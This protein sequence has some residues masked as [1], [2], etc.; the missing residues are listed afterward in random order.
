MDASSAHPPGEEKSK[1]LPPSSPFLLS[2]T[3]PLLVAP[4]LAR[5]QE[6][7]QV[8]EAAKG[9]TCVKR[10]SVAEKDKSDAFAPEQHTQYHPEFFFAKLWCQ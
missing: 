2:F 9:G 3:P 10:Q 6:L 4:Y 7:H 8:G 1:L 5:R